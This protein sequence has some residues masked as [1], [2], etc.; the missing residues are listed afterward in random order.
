MQRRLTGSKKLRRF[1]QN[2]DGVIAIL[3]ALLLV[4]L[5]GIIFGGIDYSRAMSLKSQ[6]QTAADAAAVSA[7]NRLFEGKDKAKEAFAVSFKENLPDDLKD[8]PY[9]LEI[10]GDGSALQVAIKASVP[11]TMVSMF[12]LTELKVSAATQA[13]RPSALTGAGGR[14]AGKAAAEALANSG[15]RGRALARPSNADLA[16]AQ[17]Q[18]QEAMR[19]YGG[20]SRNA[21]QPKLPDAAEVRRMQEMIQ[22]QLSKLRF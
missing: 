5:L 16:A 1:S 17:R 19:A 9:E 7:A 10:E 2:E 11:T 22:R 3:F 13:H 20:G 14:S 6:L 15:I 12:G 18:M 4:P 21:Q 8:H